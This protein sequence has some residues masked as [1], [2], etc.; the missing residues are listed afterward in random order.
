MYLYIS[1]S[2]Y[3]GLLR[4]Q[5]HGH[6]HRACGRGQN[7][8]TSLCQ[9]TSDFN[10]KSQASEPAIKPGEWIVHDQASEPLVADKWGRHYVG[11]LQ[12]SNESFDRL[13]KKVRKRDRHWSVL[14]DVDPQSP[15]SKKNIK[16]AVTR[17]AP[18]PSRFGTE[19]RWQDSKT[20]YIYI[21]I[22]LC[23]MPA[24]RVVSLSSH[25]WLSRT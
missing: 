2:T 17:L 16:V 8:Q 22:Y 15:L 14:P 13:G 1:L 12:R 7:S 6:R 9:N 20:T 3:C 4:G 21:Y 19:T 24:A 10:P 25:Q 11:P 5:A 18:T 23:I